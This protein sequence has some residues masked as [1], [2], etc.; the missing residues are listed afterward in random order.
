MTIQY[1][2]PN[3]DAFI[4]PIR[5][6]VNPEKNYPINL[7][8][9]AIEYT[10]MYNQRSEYFT[11]LALDTT[12]PDNPNAYLIS[13][14]NPKEMGNGLVSFQR[15]FQTVPATRTETGNYSFTFPGFRSGPDADGNYTILREPFTQKVVSEV[16]YSYMQTINPNTNLT[17]VPQFQPVDS[18]SYNSNYLEATSTPTKTLYETYISSETLL[19]ATDTIVSRFTGNIWEMKN[20]KVKAI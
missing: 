3:D 12:C 2:A 20:I 17:R 8:P 18:A 9:T 13:N 11:P 7:D 1:D 19:Q 16:T 6:S 10:L 15:V 4:E 5:I 14:T